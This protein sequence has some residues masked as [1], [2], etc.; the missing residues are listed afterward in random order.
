MG[1]TDAMAELDVFFAP[2]DAS[3]AV[4]QSN[5]SALQADIALIHNVTAAKVAWDAATQPTQ[6]AA[7]NPFAIQFCVYNLL[8]S[9]Y[10]TP[11]IAAAKAGVFV[12][13]L[14]DYKNLNQPYVHTY[15]TFKDAGLLVSANKSMSQKDLSPQQRNQLNLIGVKS[16][17][18]MHMKTRYY[19]WLASPTDTVPKELVI[20][21]SLNPENTAVE[22]ED[23]LLTIQD[24]PSVITAYKQ[25]VRAVR[26]GTPFTNKYDPELPVN[27][28]FSQATVQKGTEDAA[29]ARRVLLDLVRSETEAVLISVYSMRSIEDDRS[30]LV[31][32]LCAAHQRGV[33]VAVVTD[34]GQ[35]DGEG[36]FAGGDKTVTPLR[37][38]QCGIPTYKAK[39]YAG[40]F[41]ALHHKNAIFGLS[42][43]R[44][45]WTDTANWSEASM[46]NGTSR[47]KP[48]NAETTLIIDSD[49][50][51]KGRMG[52]RFLSNFLKIFRKYGYQQACPY[53]QTSG[54]L[55]K[56]ITANCKSDMKWSQPDWVQPDPVNVTAMLVAAGGSSWPTVFTQFSATSVDPQDTQLT[57]SIN[58]DNLGRT[59][60]F[61]PSGA[62]NQ[63]T[64]T[65]DGVP[66]GAIVN[67]MLSTPNSTL[68]DG[69]APVRSVMQTFI[70]DAAFDWHAEPPVRRSADELDALRVS[71]KLN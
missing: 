8:D 65:L 59:T 17:G 31:K 53:N 55:T 60:P 49:K 69:R 48:H 58:G 26:D 63:S 52:L 34:K 11:L 68:S 57:Y 18:L 50:L 61:V 41:T 15:E 14:M 37:L 12:Q 40:R 46:G 67:V 66:F 47:S 43:R 10:I 13:V 22:N 32:E 62:P 33:A 21:G 2:Y 30:T 71:F 29:E 3:T 56:S 4:P 6:P 64:A 20:S 9:S 35:A 27:L 16:A 25:A 51:D 70:V 45:I 54:H 23:T 5:L 24:H 19:S 44:I 39:N 1:A 38:V 42:A 28:L 7:L 36:G